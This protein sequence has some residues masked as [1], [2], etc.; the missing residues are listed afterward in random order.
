M[1]DILGYKSTHITETVYQ[2][3]I[4]SAIRDGTTITGHIF[5]DNDGVSH[6]HL[7]CH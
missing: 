4:V 1:N 6:R 5:D 2:H 7:K 3:V